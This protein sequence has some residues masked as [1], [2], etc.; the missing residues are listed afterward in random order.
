MRTSFFS[1]ASTASKAAKP[2][3]LRAFLGLPFFWTL[4]VLLGCLIL[5]TSGQRD[6]GNVKD[7][8]PTSEDNPPLSLVVPR[9]KVTRKRVP[10]RVLAKTEGIITA[11]GP[12]GRRKKKKITRT[13]V[14]SAAA[15]LT[16]TTARSTTAEPDQSTADSAAQE[17][18]SAA[19][20]KKFKKL[21][22]RI[23]SVSK[24]TDGDDGKNG[25]T[26]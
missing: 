15:T 3:N 1:S 7:P 4:L 14:K 8:T 13:R 12:N 20:V 5:T 25:K 24:E 9:V 2:A 17:S 22:E 10:V 19:T 6:S 18:T 21:R 26:E 11:V 16:S 23:A